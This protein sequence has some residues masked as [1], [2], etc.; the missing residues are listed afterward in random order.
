MIDFD[1]QRI[2]CVGDIMLDRF[3]YGRIDRIS[4]EAPVPVVRMT[5]SRQMLGGVGNVARNIA[6][7][8]GHA[9]VVAQ[10]GQDHAGREL[11]GLMAGTPNIVDA[12]I[13]SD[14]IP[15]TCKTRV[16][17]AHQ[18]VVRID[19]ETSAALTPAMEQQVMAAL[20]RHLPGASG[21]ILS[22]YAKGMLTPAVVGHAM[23]LARRHQVPVFVDPKQAD[24]AY[25]R[26]ATV[27]TPNAKELATATGMPV[28]T[29]AEVAAAAQQVMRAAE[30]A[31]VLVTRS[32]RGMTLV[33]ANGAVHAVPAVAR[34]VFDVSGAGDTVIAVLALSRSA[35]APL[36]QA[37]GVANAAA[38]VVVGKLGTATLDRQ[39]LAA[40]LEALVRP[41]AE[42]GS[43]F[44]SLE[45]ASQAIAGWKRQ[46][47]RVGF[48]NGC[49]DILHRGHVTLLRA[50]RQHCDRLV[51]ALNTDASVS[52]L[53]G[54]TRPINP[55][56]DRAAVI[57]AL[58]C[59]DIVLGFGEDTPFEVIGQLRPN[60]LF[61]GADYRAD[62][63]V[64]ADIVQADGGEVVL[65]PLVPDRSTTA[66]IARSQR[67]PAGGAA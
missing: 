32:E 53:K 52:R 17:A 66:I 12:C 56:E 41:T 16:I 39:E 8:G 48:T 67:P 27:I 19:E 61:K 36:A 51:V 15:T 44:I 7:L 38:G 45:A 65:L 47:L 34:E 64:G 24:M 63:V 40:A 35:G 58:Q 9:V 10:L 55:L 42:E 18:H 57:E 23:A 31:A 43:K 4:P 21:V 62:Q 60:V 5:E 59:V 46:G 14:S 30:A 25:Y 28:G 11:R 2:I 22:D 37:M 20:D 1:S 49:F 6:S 3:F 54:P 50:A 33:E 13:T 26:G 29:D